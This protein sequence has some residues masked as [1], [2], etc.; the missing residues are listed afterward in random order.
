V[1][2]S[3]RRCNLAGC[4]GGKTDLIGFVVGKN[5]ELPAEQCYLTAWFWFAGMAKFRMFLTAKHTFSECW[6]VRSFV[7][8]VFLI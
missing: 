5:S 8:F 7:S 4:A 3:S 1:G 2:K 6:I